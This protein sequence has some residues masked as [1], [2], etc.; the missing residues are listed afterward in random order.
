MPDIMRLYIRQ[1]LSGFGIAAFFV[2]ALLYFNV[3][4]IGYLVHNT[5]AGPLA[6]FLLWVFNGIVFA[7]VQFGIAVMRLGDVEDEDGPRG[8]ARV[9]VRVR[10]EAPKRR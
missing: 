2:A 6:A 7:G 10:A 5:D 9:P 3:S 4:N 1:C 8:G